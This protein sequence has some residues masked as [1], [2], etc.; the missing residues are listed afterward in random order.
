MFEILLCHLGFAPC[1]DFRGTYTSKEEAIY[2]TVQCMEMHDY[3][4][5]YFADHPP[6]WDQIKNPTGSAIHFAH[7]MSESSGMKFSIGADKSPAERR[8]NILRECANF[9]T[10]FDHDYNWKNL[11]K[12][13]N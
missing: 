13:D 10:A 2:F 5:H 4:M 8:N 12:R 11:D 6:G 3:P 9:Q 7:R 1:L